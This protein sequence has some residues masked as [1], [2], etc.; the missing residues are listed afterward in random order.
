M[1]KSVFILASVVVLAIVLTVVLILPKPQVQNSKDIS[2]PDFQKAVSFLY[3]YLC[4]NIWDLEIS[5]VNPE[6]R[7]EALKF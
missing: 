1:K 4:K 6:L 3:R 7:D 2:H 5:A